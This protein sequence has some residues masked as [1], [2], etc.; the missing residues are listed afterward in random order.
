M[1]L[2]HSVTTLQGETDLKS[3]EYH[4]M[5]IILDFTV[6]SYNMCKMNMDNTGAV[7]MSAL[8]Y[9]NPNLQNLDISQ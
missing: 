2:F 3:L 4:G 7:L 1:E 8:L 6:Q 9:T 5:M